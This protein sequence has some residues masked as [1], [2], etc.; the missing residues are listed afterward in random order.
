VLQNARAT[1]GEAGLVQGVSQM[2][3]GVFKPRAS[4]LASGVANEVQRRAT[5]KALATP[6]FLRDGYQVWTRFRTGVLTNPVWI[7]GAL[8]A[9][10]GLIG[11]GSVSCT[12]ITYILYDL[13]GIRR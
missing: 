1:G 7:A 6:G 12:G 10:V 3:E 4:N 5:S 8:I 2:V 9:L 13:F 11:T